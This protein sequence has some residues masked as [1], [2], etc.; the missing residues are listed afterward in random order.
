MIVWEELVS[1]NILPS[2][3]PTS[4]T[5]LSSNHL[6]VSVVKKFWYDFFKKL[7]PRGYFFIISEMLKHAWVTLHRPPP[8][9]FTFDSNLPVFSTRI[10]LNRVFRRAALTAQKKPA[11]PPPITTNVFFT[12]TNNT[13]HPG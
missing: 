5:P 1:G 11:A 10:T 8:L 6:M 4:F 7:L 13:R 12:S 9:T 3:S 2:S